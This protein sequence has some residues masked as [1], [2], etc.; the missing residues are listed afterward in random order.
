[1]LTLELG[2]SES[3]AEC[4]DAVR[5]SAGR[6]DVLV[7]NAGFPLVGAVEEVSIDEIEHEFQVNLFG[8]LRLTKALLPMMRAQ[9]AGR[10]INI[11]SA[12]AFVPIPFYGVYGASKAALERLSFSLRQELAPF[13]LHVSVVSPSSHRTGVQWTFPRAMQAEY[14][15][16]RNRMESAMRGTIADG[17][18]PANVARVVLRA[19][20]SARPKARYLVGADARAFGFVQRL[21]SHGFIERVIRAKF[22]LG[23]TP[24]VPL[25]HGGPCSPVQAEQK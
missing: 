3:I 22:K 18:P 4:A 17:P 6:L 21:V 19:A 24:A 11:S 10:I 12:A 9:G 25:L 7:N 8:G 23:P 15:G 5:A 1:M 16:S 2:A 13:G 20:T 14:D